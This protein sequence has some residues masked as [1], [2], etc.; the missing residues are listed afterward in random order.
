MLPQTLD[1]QRRDGELHEENGDDNNVSPGAERRRHLY[2]AAQVGTRIIPRH[3]HFDNNRLPLYKSRA[4]KYFLK[5]FCGCCSMR[6]FCE[7]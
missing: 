4:C 7:L 6:P 5:S 1:E 3:R 2:Q